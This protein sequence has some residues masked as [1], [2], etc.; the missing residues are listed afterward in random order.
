MKIL[1]KSNKVKIIMGMLCL[2]TAVPLLAQDNDTPPTYD[3]EPPAEEDI[4]TSIDKY[5]MLLAGAGVFAGYKF[6]K[7]K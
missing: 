7:A 2:F 5:I 3:D 4:P 6:L 1:T